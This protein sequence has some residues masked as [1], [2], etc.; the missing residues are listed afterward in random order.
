MDLGRLDRARISAVQARR[1]GHHQRKRN[2][3]DWD[4]GGGDGGVDDGGG[5]DG[6]ADGAHE[7]VQHP[8]ATLPNQGHPTCQNEAAI[9]H[10]G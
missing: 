5:V 6:W 7:G 3:K 4:S 9:S 1:P 2:I 10:V 8:Q